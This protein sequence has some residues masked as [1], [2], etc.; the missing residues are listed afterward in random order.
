MLFR[1][2]VD[3]D[4]R[5]IIEISRSLTV[6]RDSG[7]EG[8]IE[9]RTPEEDEM[10][11][12]IRATP[13]FYVAEDGSRNIAGFFSNFPDDK[14]IV[15]VDDEIAAHISKKS[16]PFVYCDQLGIDKNYQR[17]GIT[18]GLWA[19]LFYGLVHSDYRI[20]WTA[21]SHKPIRNRRSI[22]GIT[23]SGFGLTEE[24]KVYSG[25]TFGIYKKVLK[26]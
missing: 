25:M 23:R 24:I 3:S 13:Y 1:H 8:F 7:S 11:A 16:R 14:L 17:R 20:L 4:A 2:A 9:Y 5:R 6:S 21:V 12:R 22:N 15:L 26:F 19:N 10:K 18:T